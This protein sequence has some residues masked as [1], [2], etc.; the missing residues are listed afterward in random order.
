MNLCLTSLLKVD[1]VSIF[2]DL[3]VCFTFFKTSLEIQ[4]VPEPESRSVLTLKYLPLLAR[5]GMMMVGHIEFSASLA[6]LI[7]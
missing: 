6:V 4:F 7:I 2:L 5:I 3:T 1:S